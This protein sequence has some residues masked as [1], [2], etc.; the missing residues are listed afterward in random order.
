MDKKLIMIERPAK[1]FRQE[2]SDCK[3][4]VS[5]HIVFRLCSK[6]VLVPNIEELLESDQY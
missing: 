4:R 3:L 2:I 6:P 1:E 5:E